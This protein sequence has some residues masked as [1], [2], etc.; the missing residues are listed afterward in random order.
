MRSFEAE[1]ADMGTPQPGEVSADPEDMAQIAGE[2]PNIRAHR[3]G[4]AHVDI[5]RAL[6]RI[7][8]MDG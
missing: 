4:D 5:A 8:F 2:R 7:R 3:A 1:R 6:R